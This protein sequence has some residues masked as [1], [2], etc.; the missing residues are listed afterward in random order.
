M[1]KMNRILF[2]ILAALACVKGYAQ[3]DPL[4]TQSFDNMIYVNPAYAGSRGMLNF[5]DLSRV[6]WVGFDGNPRS[7]AL[8]INSPIYNESLGGGLNLINDVVGPVK[9]TLVIPVFS[10]H[11]FTN[12]NT[13]S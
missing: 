12:S 9:Q 5:T 7:N 13:R 10:T 8:S 2:V 1:R 11:S 4:F 6:Q 3:Q